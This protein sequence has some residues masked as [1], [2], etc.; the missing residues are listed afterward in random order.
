M[1]GIYQPKPFS[2]IR[3][4]LWWFHCLFCF[5]GV[6][7]FTLTKKDDQFQLHKI[8]AFW[9]ISTLTLTVYLAVA[10]KLIIFQPSRHHWTHYQ[11][12]TIA[13][14]ALLA[15]VCTSADAKDNLSLRKN[16]DPQDHR[17]LQDTAAPWY[18]TGIPPGSG[19]CAAACNDGCFGTTPEACVQ[20]CSI[21][22]T[23]GGCITECNEGCFGA[24]TPEACAFVCTIQECLEGCSAGSGTP[25]QCADE[26]NPTP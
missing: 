4:A 9:S 15:L 1:G 14:A 6:H 7:A 19:A 22:F 16:Q 24:G 13:I 5:V 11:K 25:Q 23:P 8:T 20:A 3:D 21:D 10:S 12:T 18:K 17:H 2:F 26:C